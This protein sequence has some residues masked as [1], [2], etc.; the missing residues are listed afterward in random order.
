ML[1]LLALVLLLGVCPNL[2]AKTKVAEMQLWMSVSPSNPIVG[3][4]VT[5]SVVSS[6]GSLPHRYTWN[7][8]NPTETPTLYNWTAP[9]PFYTTRTMKFIYGTPGT[10]SITVTAQSGNKEI[11]RTL[12]LDV[13]EGR[14]TLI[15]PNGGDVWQ[16]GKT[17]N[18]RWKTEGKVPLVQ[19][20]LWDDRYNS[21]TGNAGEVLIAA[22]TANTG[23]FLY[24]VPMPSSDGISAGNLGGR[25]YKVSVQGWNPCFAGMS[26]GK[27][28]I[29]FP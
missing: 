4:E 2:F 21:E 14:I 12:S 7:S 18:I 16:C 22:Q 24:K 26:A 3:E 10:K 23:S 27:F 29:K 9:Y 8:S 11:T 20:G 13:V 6:G 28:T 1:R 17:Y 19:I 15:T 25:N 5:W